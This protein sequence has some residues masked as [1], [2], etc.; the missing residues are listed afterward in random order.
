MPDARSL[1]P[2]PR[3]SIVIPTKDGAQTLPQLLVALAQQKASFDHEIV[4]ID[5]G[6]KEGSVEILREHGAQVESIPPADFNHGETRNLGV[7]RTRGEFIALLNE[8]TAE[9]GSLR[10]QLKEYGQHKPSCEKSTMGQSE[11]VALLPKGD[12]TCG[13]ADA[14]SAEVKTT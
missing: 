7:R 10:R 1:A 11:A 9:R 6:S 3:V 4:A 8:V 13:L 14:L 5:S 12:C 2:E